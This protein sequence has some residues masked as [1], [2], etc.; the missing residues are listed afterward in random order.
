MKASFPWEAVALFSV[1]LWYATCGHVEAAAILAAVSG[2]WVRQ[3][4]DR[5]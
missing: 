4:M 1:G 5:S 3:W 2:R